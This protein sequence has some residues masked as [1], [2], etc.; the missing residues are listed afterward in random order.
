MCC[1][2]YGGG[3]RLLKGSV[4]PIIGPGSVMI[5]T[6]PH[7]GHMKKSLTAK[8]LLLVF[9]PMM[10]YVGCREDTA[11]ISTTD[12]PVGGTRGATVLINT[13]TPEKVA[14]MV[15]DTPGLPLVSVLSR[16][17]KR[18]FIARR[19][20]GN[21]AVFVV[22]TDTKTVSE[23]AIESH[24]LQLRKIWDMVLS[25]DGS[26]LLIGT[27]NTLH[28]DCRVEIYDTASL[29]RKGSFS[30]KRHAFDYY[31]IGIKLAVNPVKDE[32][33]AMVKG[34]EI[35][36][37]RIRALTFAGDFLG[38]DLTMNADHWDYHYGFGVSSNGELLMG[39]SDRIYPYKI[40]DGGLVALPPITGKDGEAFNYYGEIKVLFSEDFSVVYVTSSGAYLAGT[41]NLGGVCSVLNVE[42]IVAGD[43]DPF[44]HSTVDFIYDDFIKWVA[45]NL[46]STVGELLDPLQ[47]YG[48]ADACMVGNTCYVIIASVAGLGVDM[49]DLIDGK[50]ILSAFET[51]PLGGQVWLGGKVL[52]QY[53]GHLTVNGA[54]D[55]LMVTYPWNGG[56]DIFKKSGSWL[57]PTTDHVNLEKVAELGSAVYP[58]HVTLGAVERK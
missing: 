4:L 44:I 3:L 2:N 46:S 5:Q 34:D 27:R 38:E 56:V 53:P 51:L 40:R 20:S 8:V 31:R 25:G 12:L 28:T 49:A 14:P 55:T 10:L 7:G 42:K 35:Q 41:T 54:N 6:T 9:L 33:Y 1:G 26:K 13:N 17:M 36:A 52:S 43:P 18:V 22:D 57:T 48:I 15:L 19:I 24:T 37:V 58:K 45:G 32:L 30:L 21:D 50:Y 16:D 11:V 47:L 39:V 23:M 29:G